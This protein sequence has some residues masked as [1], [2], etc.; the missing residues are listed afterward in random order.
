GISGNSFGGWMT[1][2]LCCTTDRFRAGVAENPVTDL[3][4][5][6]YTSDIG[7][8]FMALQM[9]GDVQTEIE[10]Y[11]RW[12]PLLQAH[13]CRTPLL[14]VSGDQDDRCPPTQAKELAAALHRHGVPTEVL[15]L[16]GAAHEGS[17]FGPVAGRRA[18]NDALVEWMQRWLCH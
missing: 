13:R 9:G 18:Q 5:M 14:F 1:S 6:S 15:V 11:L 4:S 17:A 7:P 2:W 12:S 10:R 3:L 16:P 8:E